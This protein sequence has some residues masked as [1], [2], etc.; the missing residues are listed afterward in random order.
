MFWNALFKDLHMANPSSSFISKLKSL[1]SLRYALPHTFESTT[2][3]YY[4]YSAYQSLKFDLLICFFV[5]FTHLNISY[6]KVENEHC[7]PYSPGQPIEQLALKDYLS[8]VKINFNF[9]SK[10]SNQS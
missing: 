3:F 1:P 7:P 10:I 8:N 9:N 4:L 6:V 5:H 2:L